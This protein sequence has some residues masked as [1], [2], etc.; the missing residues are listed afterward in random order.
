MDAP[1]RRDAL[2][3]LEAIGHTDIL[4]GIPSLNNQ[5]TI[6]HVV[7]QAAEG[8]RTH[9][10]AHACALMVA[11]GGS[12]D[13]TRETALQVP[14]KGIDRVVTIYRGIPGKGSA[15]RAILQAMRLLGVGTG[16]LVDADLRSIS[17]EWIRLLAAPIHHGRGNVKCFSHHSGKVISQ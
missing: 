15:V 3:Q 1:L 14:V 8:L 6:G 9:F 11:D 10:N 16:I 4:V 13:D 12:T 7:G 2:S 17:P 5:D